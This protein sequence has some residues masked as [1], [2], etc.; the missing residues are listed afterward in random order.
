MMLFS[1]F[2]KNGDS[3][4]GNEKKLSCPG[5]VADREVVTDWSLSFA[6]AFMAFFLKLQKI[7]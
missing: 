6:G 4:T 2:E 3:C 7:K 5:L 1:P